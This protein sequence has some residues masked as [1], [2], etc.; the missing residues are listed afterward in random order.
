MSL[1]IFRFR[2]SHKEIYDVVLKK[3]T[4]SVVV[5][6]Q[7]GAAELAARPAPHQGPR[8]PLGEVRPRHSQVRTGRETQVPPCK[9]VL[10]IHDI[11]M[12][13]RIRGLMDP[14]PDPAFFV[15]DLQDANK[16]RI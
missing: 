16:K 8:R 1:K 4:V 10:R 5:C 3:C 2:E 9:A 6:E 15:I 13:I 12:W 14:D 11:L 7:S